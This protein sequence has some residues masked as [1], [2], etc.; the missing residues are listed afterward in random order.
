MLGD[1]SLMVSQITP[2]LMV[3]F[4]FRLAFQ[5]YLYLL[6]EHSCFLTRIKIMAHSGARLSKGWASYAWH[7]SVRL[8]THCSI[9]AEECQT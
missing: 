5:G 1:N 8:Q 9:L 2:S 4:S 7:S 6:L 3:D